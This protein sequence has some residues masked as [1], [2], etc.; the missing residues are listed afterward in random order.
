MKGYKYHDGDTNMLNFFWWKD[1]KILHTYL[2]LL[3]VCVLASRSSKKIL[4][5]TYTM[6]AG[7]NGS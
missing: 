5:H 3:L 1:Y 4:L 7:G 2:F 6:I